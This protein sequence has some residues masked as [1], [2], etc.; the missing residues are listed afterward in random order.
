MSRTRIGP[1]DLATQ[2]LAYADEIEAAVIR[3]LRSGKYVLGEEV[4]A[5]ENEL[6]AWLGAPHV[7]TC[8]SGTAAL[9]LSLLALPLAPGDEV[10]VPAFTIFIDAE[11]VALLGGVPRFVDVEAD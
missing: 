10:L 7:V 3:V 11:V 5:F 1:V 9:T 4:A 6:A 2:H 8:A